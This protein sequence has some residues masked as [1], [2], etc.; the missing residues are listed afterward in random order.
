MSQSIFDLPASVLMASGGD[1][2]ITLDENNGLN[3]YGC[4]PYPSFTISYSSSTSNTISAAAY[5]H[6][7]SF[8]YSLRQQCVSA[9][10]GQVFRD[11]FEVV[12]QA[13]RQ[14]YGCS[15][16]DR[17]FFGASGTDLEL[18]VLALAL[19]GPERRAHNIILGMDEVGS[20]IQHASMGRY[21]SSGTPLGHTCQVGTSIEGFPEDRITMSG[22][23]I[24]DAN[25]RVRS[26]DALATDLDAEVSQAIECGR[27][28][29]VHVV[30][31]SKTGMVV[32]DWDL[33][34][35][36][37]VKWEGRADV[38]VDACQ[39]RISPLMLRSYL[40]LGCS[41]LYTG[42]KF[43]GG[44]PFSGALFVP[45]QLANRFKHPGAVPQGLFGIF[46]PA[47]WPQDL[48]PAS[49]GHD[50]A[51]NLGLLLRW[52]A[53][54]YELRRVTAID[55]DR[56]RFT[57]R[58]FQEEVMTMVE[59][60]P[61]LGMVS[62]LEGD[63]SIAEECREH[64]FERD[65][66]MTMTIGGTGAD[67]LDLE[68]G[69]FIYRSMFSDLELADG[70]QDPIANTHIQL[71]QP[72]KCRKLDDGRWQATLRVSLGAPTI[73][74]VAFASDEAIRARF[75]SDMGRIHRKLEL[76]LEQIR[77]NRGVNITA[78]L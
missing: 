53:A 4:A 12:R 36:A 32:P 61:W 55:E 64:P 11:R 29:I 48:V 3:G 33:L 69:K 68:D 37:M 14:V 65:M 59:R 20:G 70:V 62:E 74:E 49:S 18:I 30:H 77:L 54:I 47:E 8:L 71:G 44:P 2:R 34:R 23:A 27:R 31:R 56:L 5:A 51:L 22:V 6:V 16:Q 43:I 13:L 45:E 17:I 42:S 19:N 28:P 38:V 40:A 25:G 39:G 41:V 9:K 63:G 26:M 10:V 1:E 60:S 73:S 50:E 58:C 78:Q 66:I 15:E 7:E 24:R 72:V 46:S 35:N 21:I 52:E 75:V 76:V 57:I 67:G